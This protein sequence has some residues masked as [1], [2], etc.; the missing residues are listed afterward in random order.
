MSRLAKKPILIPQGATV[1]LQSGVLSVKG[2]KGELKRTLPVE[3]AVTAST[4]DITVR[5]ADGAGRRGPILS[6]TYASHIRN[7]LEG[8]TKGFEK[9]LEI[10][11]IGFRAEKK[12]TALSLNVGLSH[13][14]VIEPRPSVTFGVEKNVIIVS[15]PDKEL[16]GDEAAR[17]RRVRPPEPYKGTGIRYAGEII[18]RKAGKKMVATAG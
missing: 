10:E 9:R 5:V 16:V 14:V 13:S 12:G 7:M 18:R 6:G 17:V 4:S 11:G 3:L 15:G 2:P 1:E 8:A